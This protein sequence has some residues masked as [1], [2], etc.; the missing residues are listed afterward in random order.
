[1]STRSVGEGIPKWNLGTR[2]SYGFLKSFLICN[3]CSYVWILKKREPLE[4]APRWLQTAWAEFL[5][6]I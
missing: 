5:S 2:D 1:M 3:P 4:K 6:P